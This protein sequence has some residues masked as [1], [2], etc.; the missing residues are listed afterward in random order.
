MHLFSL[1]EFHS[2]RIL[3]C[4]RVNDDGFWKVDEQKLRFLDFLSETSAGRFSNSMLRYELVDVGKYRHRYAGETFS[5]KGL[6]V[7]YGNRIISF[8]FYL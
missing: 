6:E 8:R 5:R 4:P 2:C 7:Q 1:Y 3:R